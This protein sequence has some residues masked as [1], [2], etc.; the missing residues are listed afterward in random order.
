MKVCPICHKNFPPEA[1][2]CPKDGSPLA[3]IQDP[4][5]GITLLG[6][7]Q[8]QE[9]IGQ[10]S[11]GKVYLAK[12]LSVDR[13]VAVKVLKQK[14]AI[15]DKVVQRFH[16]EARAAA[17]LNHPNIITIHLVGE[18]DGTRT[19]Y[20]VM[21]YVEG[22]SLETIIATQGALDPA[23]VIKISIQIATALLEAHKNH[24]VH[25]DLKP[26]NIALLKHGTSGETVKV[27][28][29]GI[30]KILH[31]D[32]EL[33]QLTKT[34]TIFGTPAY[35]SPE[36]AGGEP[37]D[38]R[39][40]LYSLGV[41][42][43]RMATG[44][45]PFENASGLEI[46]VR[47]IKDI[48]PVP[49]SVNPQIPTALELVILRLL[50]KKPVDRYNT[51]QDLIEALQVALKEVEKSSESAD[52][53]LTASASNFRGHEV[54]EF[55]IKPSKAKLYTIISIIFMLATA[56]VY[57]AVKFLNRGSSSDKTPPEI[58]QQ[59]ETKPGNTPPEEKTRDVKVDE[60]KVVVPP[61]KKDL[62][63]KCEFSF[64]EPGKKR[65]TCAGTTVDIS[66]DITR[67][68]RRHV[69]IQLYIPGSD[70]RKISASPG[71]K[72]DG[73]EIL[74]KKFPEKDK[75]MITLRVPSDGIQNLKF[76]LP[77]RELLIFVKLTVN[78]KKPVT[79][80]NLNHK[81][82]NH[83]KRESLVLPALPT[84]NTMKREELIPPFPT[85]MI[86]P[87]LPPPPTTMKSTK[88]DLP[89]F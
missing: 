31:S 20:M 2:F 72:S 52:S 10:G 76:Q 38:F 12:Q 60:K 43:Y 55:Q 68:S 73:L 36:Q 34:G 77:S 87:V 85:D 78:F 9:L 11:M 39:T 26:E 50:E 3:D 65:H 57:G 70:A 74:R 75:Y 32:E 59:K 64:S 88:P 23:R 48:P 83:K 79:K 84:L 28:D 58:V 35:I 54:N 13:H 14:L 53:N 21:E 66:F 37:L 80:T 40:D 29:F 5:L 46:L 6:Q 49:S 82:L 27:L 19:P 69:T 8:V 89:D 24:V 22:A 17:R 86:E 81:K 15:D 47:H 51:A 30:A 41:I 7:F 4:L 18:M 61:E 45:L 67:R 16:R 62:N 1:H 42:M 56:S 33:S 71:E 63:K 44:H 25:R